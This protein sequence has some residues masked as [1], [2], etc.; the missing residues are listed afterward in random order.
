[1]DVNHITLFSEEERIQIR[2]TSLQDYQ[3]GGCSSTVTQ[4]VLVP[5]IEQ[6][7]LEDQRVTLNILAR[8]ENIDKGITLQHIA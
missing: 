1:M 2:W 5:K 6:L 4:P 8:E 3:K 7:I